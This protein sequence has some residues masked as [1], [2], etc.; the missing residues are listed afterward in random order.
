LQFKA[1]APEPDRFFLKL[2]NIRSLSN[3]A[4]LAVYVGLQPDADPEAHPEA[5][6]GT[7][8]MFGVRNASLRGK[9]RPGNGV[10]QTFEITEVL[11]K[12]QLADL[13]QLTVRFVPLRKIG[14]ES[15]ASIGRI[16]IFRQGA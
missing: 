5:F 8:S 4:S 2:E 16:S 13:R 3:A 7:V 1:G 12:L 6:V 10:S 14:P 9:G 11:D 15:E